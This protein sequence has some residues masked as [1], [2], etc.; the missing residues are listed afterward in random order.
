MICSLESMRSKEVIDVRTGDKLGYIDDVEMNLENSGIVALIIYGRER[1]F[2]LLG[3]EED[4]IIP[5]SEIEVIG[6]EVL[7]IKHSEESKPSYSTKNKRE[8][9]TRL[10][11]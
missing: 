4:I 10:F 9:I 8:G 6:R 11:K 7:L 1:L 5:C 2:G 3:R